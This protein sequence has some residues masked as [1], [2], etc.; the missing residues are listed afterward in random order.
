MFGVNVFVE[1]RDFVHEV[2]TKEKTEVVEQQT[3]GN[4]PTDLKGCG[5]TPGSDL[6]RTTGYGNIPDVERQAIEGQF[7]GPESQMPF[8][9]FRGRR[10][11]ERRG[12]RLFCYGCSTIVDSIVLFV[13]D[14]HL[15]PMVFLSI[16][17]ILQTVAFPGMHHPPSLI[18][19]RNRSIDEPE[20]VYPE[21]EG[22][23]GNHPLPVIVT[24]QTWEKRGGIVL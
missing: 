23:Y 13:S 2:V 3:T 6:C 11:R 14:T 17:L 1:E 7:E 10:R 18:G 4:V 8:A 20:T 24:E 21:K 12:Q 22:P 19:F 16:V 15:A 9:L 5:C